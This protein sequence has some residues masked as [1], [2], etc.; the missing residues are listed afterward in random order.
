MPLKNLP[1][2]EPTRVLVIRHGQTAWNADARIQ[3]HTDI[4]LDAVGAWQA[5]RLAQALGGDEL[6]AIYSSDLENSSASGH[7]VAHRAAYRG[8][9]SV[10]GRLTR[11]ARE[12]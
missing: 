12:R 1:L 11:G 9:G 7:P 2:A 10:A 4:G 3:G 5:E 8:R 6:H